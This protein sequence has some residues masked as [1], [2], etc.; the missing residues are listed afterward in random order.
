MRSWTRLFR[1]T[2]SR[3][4][5]VYSSSGRSDDR[6]KSSGSGCKK[7]T[8][9]ANREMRWR[10]STSPP[11][12]RCFWWF[13]SVRVTAHDGFRDDCLIP[14]CL[15][16]HLRWWYL[17]SSSP[18]STPPSGMEALEDMKVDN[19]KLRVDCSLFHAGPYR[20]LAPP[21]SLRCSDRFRVDSDFLGDEQGRPVLLVTTRITVAVAWRSFSTLRKV[22]ASRFQ[23]RMSKSCLCPL[24]QHSQALPHRRHRAVRELVVHPLFGRTHEDSWQLA[25]PGCGVN[26]RFGGKKLL[27]LPVHWTPF[28]SRLQVSWWSSSSLSSSGWITSCSMTVL[29]SR[30]TRFRS[31][32]G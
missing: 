28:F 21:L 6:G 25:V 31:T 14:V 16:R 29:V 30:R 8:T 4:P 19:I 26:V 9:A 15:V 11:C 3:R 1:F 10:H 23:A 13:L 22:P 27:C 7:E 18:N 24:S 17:T 12:A 32:F 20:F 2:F 5:P